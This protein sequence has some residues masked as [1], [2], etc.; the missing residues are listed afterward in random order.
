MGFTCC[1]SLCIDSRSDPLNCSAC[2]MTCNGGQTLCC[3][4]ACANP[5]TEVANCRQVGTVLRRAEQHP[6]VRQRQLRLGLHP[7]LRDC[8]MDTRLRDAHQHTAN[9]GAATTCA[10]WPTPPRH[11]DG[12]RC[13][14]TCKPGFGDCSKI[15]A[16]TDGCETAH[17]TIMNCGG[18][19]NA[20]NLNNATGATCT[21][22]KCAYTCKGGFADCLQN[23]ANTD[24][25]ESDLT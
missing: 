18:C 5:L 8:A 25:C 6:L 1:N 2:G 9:C 3:N 20:C 16:D 17:D 19:G 22:G 10:T 12:T 21:N 13:A 15:G 7:G 24:G 23:G 14:Y 11:C 4:A